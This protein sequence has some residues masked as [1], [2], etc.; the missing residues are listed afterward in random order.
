MT[1][2]RSIPILALT[3]AFGLPLHAGSRPQITAGPLDGPIVIDGQESDW[4]GSLQPFGDQPFSIQAV[5]DGADLY[6]RVSASSPAVRRE[7]LRRGLTVWFDPKG[8]SKKTFGIRYPVIEE[9]FDQG[10]RGRGG[11]GR[12]GRGGA[13]EGEPSAESDRPTEEPDAQP[14]PSD[15]VDIL[16]PGKSDARSLTR[17]HLEGVQVALR[18]DQG[19][20]LYE[21][22]VPLATGEGRPYA[23]GTSPGQTIGIG[24]ETAKIITPQAGRGGGGF[25][26]GGY[27]GGGFG[28]G[29]RGPGGGGRGGGMARANVQP[30]KPLK[31]WATLVLHQ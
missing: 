28:G 6:V 14:E 10:E 1:R 31:A 24:F 20:L 21:L 8:G 18:V 29:R 3:F 12:R 30:P 15:R 11:F 17:D 16:G 9:P 26:G 4:S 22:K 23:I 13:P 19:V 7:I 2:R 5:N 25:G 27:G